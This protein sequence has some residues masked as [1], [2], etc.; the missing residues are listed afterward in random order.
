MISPPFERKELAYGEIE[1]N[2]RGEVK[3]RTRRGEIEKYVSEFNI[4][5]V[6]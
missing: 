3:L 4:N 6:S 1:V 2:G 5:N